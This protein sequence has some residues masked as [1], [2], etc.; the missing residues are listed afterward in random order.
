MSL[1]RDKIRLDAY[2]AAETKILNG[3]FSVEIEGMKFQSAELDK[4]QK[5]IDELEERI[6]QQDGSGGIRVSQVVF[7]GGR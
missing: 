4:I 6:A 2:L 5:K 3:S 7:G 1:E